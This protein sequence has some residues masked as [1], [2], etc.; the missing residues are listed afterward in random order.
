VTITTIDPRLA[1]VVVD[2]QKG[3]LGTST[4]PYPMA[5]VIQQAA[6][7]ATSFRSRDLPVVLVNVTGGAPGLTETGRHNA[8]RPPDWADLV[9]ALDARPSDVRITKKRWGAFHET[10]LDATLRALGVTQ[11]VLAGV[12]TS[13]GV[14]STARSAYE[15][16]YNVILATDAMSDIDSAAHT[17]SIERIFPKLGELGSVDE[18]LALIGNTL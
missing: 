4:T 8:S 10:P 2:L 15:H 3:F 14:E 5:E 12:A 11:V 18:I 6:K 17:N 7:L 13:V 16:E 1:L 9:D